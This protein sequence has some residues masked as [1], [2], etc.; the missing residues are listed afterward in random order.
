MM[1]ESNNSKKLKLKKIRLEAIL[2]N[3]KFRV[4][5]N[6]IK[7]E[8][9]NTNTKNKLYSLNNKN[10]Y[11]NTLNTTCLHKNNKS[12]INLKYKTPHRKNNLPEINKTIYT[13]KDIK[14][15][16][17]ISIDLNGGYT[18]YLKEKKNKIYRKMKHLLFEQKLKRLS[19]PKYRHIINFENKKASNSIST[20]YNYQNKKDD[21]YQ[22]NENCKYKK[23]LND[24]QLIEKEKIKERKRYNEILLIN[25]KKLDSCETKFNSAIN[26]TLKLLSDYQHSL[27]YLKNEK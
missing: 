8:R 20:R 5:S 10:H 17:K 27:G 24:M 15:R 4:E 6:N 22:L 1:D 23:H 2:I 7:T 14:K 25:F 12:I 18:S 16:N 26:K 21:Y 19:L 11:L 13:K 3:N 9:P